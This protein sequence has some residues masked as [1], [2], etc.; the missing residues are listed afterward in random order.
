MASYGERPIA[1]RACKARLRPETENPGRHD[2]LTFIHNLSKE[3]FLIDAQAVT[4]MNAL[5]NSSGAGHTAE[6][7]T[8][9]KRRTEISCLHK[10]AEQEMDRSVLIDRT[11]RNR[12]GIESIISSVSV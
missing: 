11:A 12:R 3:A 5:L 6:Q 1:D 2:N 8:D 9:E 7:R 4:G 10:P